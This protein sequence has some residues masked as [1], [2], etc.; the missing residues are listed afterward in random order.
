MSSLNSYIGRVIAGRYEIV[1]FLGSGGMADVFKGKHLQ[2]NRFVA[3]KLMHSFLAEDE[4][5]RARFEREAQAVAQ[6][7]HPNIVQVYDFDLSPEDRLYYM[8]MEYIEGPTLRKCIDELTGRGKRIP[9]DEALRIITGVGKALAYAHKRDMIHRDVKPANVMIGADGRVVLT[10]FGIVKM[11]GGGS[12]LTA[13]GGMLGTPAYMAPEQALGE[14][15]DERADIYSLG[16]ILYQLCTGR[17]P[18]E[19]N[20][21]LA[22]ILK[23]V[24][25]PLPNPRNLNPDLPEGVEKIIFRAMAK[26][27]NVRYQDA[28]E[29]VDHLGDLEAAAQ[30]T[31]VA[32]PIG[33]PARDDMLRLDTVSTPVVR[34][35]A[36]LDRR[37]NW[38]GIG[39]LVLLAFIVLVGAFALGSGII[40]GLRAAPTTKPT[41]ILTDT[42]PLTLTQ[43]PS[44]TPLPTPTPDLQATADR[45]TLV[46]LLGAF[47]TQTAAASESFAAETA[48]ALAA[49]GTSIPTITLAPSDTPT[50]TPTSTQTPVS[51]LAT[52]GHA[53]AVL[54]IQFSPEGERAATASA[55]RTVRVW[56]VATGEELLVLE[57]H[58][59]A[60]NAVVFNPVV[61]RL[62]S[63]SA[64]HT[65][66]LWNAETGALLQ[67][68]EGHTDPV[69]QVAFNLYA[70]CLATAGMDGTVRLWDPE[71]GAAVAVLAGHTDEVTDIAFSPDGTLL[72][73][74]SAD[75]TIR[76]WDVL[77]GG[78]L[79]VLEGHTAGVTDVV[80]SPDGA[81]LASAG[82]DGAIRLWNGYDGAPLAVL[83]GHDGAVTTLAYSPSGSVMGSVGIDGTVRLW[84]AA[85]GEALS[86]LEKHPGEVLRIAFSPDD[87]RLVSASADGTLQL[88]S[89][90]RGEWLATLAGHT[91]SITALAFSPDGTLLASASIDHTAR[92]WPVPG[93]RQVIIPPTRP[94]SPTPTSAFTPTPNL[95]ATIAACDYDYAVVSQRYEP[96]SELFPGKFYIPIRQDFVA[97]IRVRNTGECEWERFSELAYVSGEGFGAP[98]S[99]SVPIIVSVGEEFTFEIPMHAPPRN[100]EHTGEWVLRTPGGLPIGLP[101]KITIFAYD[102]REPATIATPVERA[103][104]TLTPSEGGGALGF[105]PSVSE[106]GYAGDDFVCSVF[107]NPGGGVPPY[108]VSS[109]FGSTA[110]G[111]PY[112]VQVRNRRC[113]S[114]AYSIS[115][116]DRAG[117]VTRQ[118]L[119]F[120]PTLEASAF[121][122]GACS[123]GD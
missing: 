87:I 88:W 83:E 36:A 118:D 58:T 14:P 120:D 6:L 97:F 45:A 108:T 117:S 51:A 38:L 85:T 34:G 9:L 103:E 16:V 60:V 79:A 1:D 68:L 107:V 111:A 27:P 49:A 104:A 95:T 114:F 56:D 69:T 40:G 13:S 23:H 70:T 122:D 26:D 31:L 5:F 77:S 75:A 30:M 109:S 115:V 86:V 113:I 94:P 39:A 44:V 89:E 90:Q 67:T 47:V 25:D 3:L 17:P 71:T 10:D 106:C 19:A 72:A 64:D 112:V 7:R 37:P 102:P 76:L 84:S 100:I 116:T 74:A 62:A 73:S 50:G 18:F 81:I 96:S 119:W 61:P 98:E 28:Q 101:L 78:L 33:P 66:R 123:L 121:P 29:M 91:G 20:T 105:T 24:N 99:I 22:I 53:D 35:G 11:A 43:L 57:G 52:L 82:S 93:T 2:L 8:V 41:T 48:S 54:D 21:P 12:T 55:D 110:V 46:A 42:A 4:Q 80:F 65:V 32:S 63:A 15:G 92:L 59:R